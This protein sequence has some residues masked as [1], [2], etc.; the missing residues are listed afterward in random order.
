VSDVHNHTTQDALAPLSI[1]A[2][3]S[4]S[5]RGTFTSRA[6]A[7]TRY[8]L[9]FWWIKLKA[10]AKHKDWDGLEAF[11]KSKKSPIGYEPFV[12]C[13][14]QLCLDY[15][16]ICDRL[17]YWH[18]THLNQIRQSTLSLDVTP[19]VVQI[20]MSCVVIGRKQP[21]RARKEVIEVN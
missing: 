9:R 2:P 4:R 3:L 17:T 14:P 6:F 15:L 12:V 19:K 1:P 7:D 18:S 13:F 20:Y 10:L 8:R 16:L 11:G 5:H 21:R